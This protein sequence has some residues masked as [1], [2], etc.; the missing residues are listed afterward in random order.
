MKE[1]VQRDNL[2]IVIGLGAS[3][4]TFLFFSVAPNRKLAADYRREI[5]RAQQTVDDL[6]QRIAEL[7]LLEAE[8]QTRRDYIQ[9]I[10]AQMEFSAGRGA[11]V[12]Q[13]AELAE[14]VGLSVSRQEP[15]PEEVR[16]TY[17]VVPYR[18]TFTGSFEQLARFLYSMEQLPIVTSVR[19]LTLSPQNGRNNG[20]VRGELTFA[21]YVN[22]RESID[23][24]DNNAS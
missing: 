13:V 7:Q 12:Q 20:Q 10:E 24:A 23:F 3:L 1:T 16:T 5:Q 14:S 18:I 11:V 8:L 15:L 2:L 6:P 9:P 22:S 19:E 21:V 17:Q 4:T